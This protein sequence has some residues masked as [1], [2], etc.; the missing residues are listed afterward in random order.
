MR[1]PAGLWLT[2]VVCLLAGSPAEAADYFFSAAGSDSNPGTLVAPWRTIAR[3]NT[4]DLA[5][6]DRVLFRGGDTF[7]GTLALDAYDAGTPQLPV[8]VSSY[9]T[10]RATIRP[11]SGPGISVYNAAGIRIVNLNVSTASTSSTSGI[12]FYTDLQVGLPHVRIEN[13]DV[14]GF[15]RDGIEIGSWNTSAGF[16]DV[17]LTRVWAHHNTRTGILVYA[18]YPLSHQDVYV[19]YSQAFDNAGDPTSPVN[20][21]SGI[22]LGGVNGGTIEWSVAYRN[23]ARNTAVGGPVGIWTYDSSRVLIQ[24]NE[25]HSNRTASTADGGGFDLD[26]NVSESILQYNYSHDNDGAGYLLAHQPNTSAHRGNIVRYNL[27]ENDGQKNSYGAIELWGRMSGAR[28]HHNTVRVTRPATGRPSAVRVWNGGVE[29]RR[30]S[31]V[32]IHDNVLTTTTGLPLVE[33]TPTQS[34]SA[35]VKFERNQYDA[36]GAPF[37]ILW[38]GAAYGSV[39]AWRVTGQETVDG[40]ATGS[41]GPAA[42]RIPS[43]Q[44]VINATNARVSGAWRKVADVSAASGVRAWHPDA[45]GAKLVTPLSDPANYVEGTFDAVA[46]RA[47][48]VW[49]RLKA[50]SNYWANDSVFVQFTDALDTDGT[51]RWRVGTTSALEVNLEDCSGCRVAEWGW[52]DTGWGAGVL[53]PVVRFA[54]DGRQTVRIQTREDGVSIDQILL[55]SALFT[56]NAPG[57]NKW[58]TTALPVQASLAAAAQTPPPTAPPEIVLYAADVAT[59]AIRGD[60]QI[61]SDATAAGG[62]AIWNPNRG[63]P[64]GSAL[65]QPSSYVDVGFNAHAGVDYQVWIRM[66]ADGDSYT[67]DSVTVQFSGAL[68]GS[69]A[70]YARIGTATGATVSLQD[71]N[72]APMSGWGWNDAG[73]ATM[74]PPIRFERTGAQKLRI[75]QRE[76]GIRIDQIVI[77]PV[78]YLGFSPGSLLNDQTIV[79]R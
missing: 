1:S 67:N 50:D 34:N 48:R 45:G 63:A 18:Q 42:A 6:G 64:K 70:H 17:R 72:G 22:V 61:V 13:V 5:P 12:L 57:P 27:S 35:N 33:I 77:S 59:S 78:R 25:S 8:T 36:S 66:R 32:I 30:A 2:V 23:G 7:D 15:G 4:I 76:D 43:D 26:Q 9:G 20:T 73:W 44:I 40:L 49:L 14:S 52:Q 31:D 29:D 60:W 58:D 28:I 79:G 21:G 55:S 53:G 10:G 11:S 39:A 38:N 62:L 3:V 56:T 46:G 54:R 37:V 24:H 75:Q 65:A 19:G 47:Y 41:E 71:T 16:R 51:S 74:A 69:G 68:D